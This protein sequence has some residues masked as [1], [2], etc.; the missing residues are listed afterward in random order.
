MLKTISIIF[1]VI[2]VVAGL[3]GF[4]GGLG[5]VGGSGIFLTDTVHD[6]IHLLTGL[7][8]L[9][10]AFWSPVFISMWLK[11]FGVIY[12]IL[13]ILGFMSVDGS[14]LGIVMANNADIYLHLVLGII[15][16][17]LPFVYKNDVRR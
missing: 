5:L 11:I 8:I 1:G 16:L 3:L 2:F 4:V 13:A 10:V 14:I 9:S 17:G 6:V 15:L 12:I 7:V